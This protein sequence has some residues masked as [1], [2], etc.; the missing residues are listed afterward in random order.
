MTQLHTE[1][2]LDIPSQQLQNVSEYYIS[3]QLRLF[4]KLHILF[5]QIKDM[6]PFI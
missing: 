4:T 6:Q 5:Y 3:L 1:A 2:K